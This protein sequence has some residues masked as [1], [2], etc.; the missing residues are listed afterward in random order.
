MRHN[1]LKLKYF[2]LNLL[3]LLIQISKKNILMSDNTNKHL[4]PRAKYLFYLCS[5]ETL[6]TYC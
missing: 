5:P 6:L 3:Q 1:V 4:R 2:Q